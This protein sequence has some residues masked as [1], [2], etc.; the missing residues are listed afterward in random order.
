MM[1]CDVTKSQLTDEAFRSS[2]L[3]ERRASVGLDFDLVNIH[4]LLHVHEKA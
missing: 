4:D 2:V 1:K 3:W